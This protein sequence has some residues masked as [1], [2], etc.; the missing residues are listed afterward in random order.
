MPPMNPS[1]FVPSSLDSSLIEQPPIDLL[2]VLAI[3]VG[4]AAGV[5]PE[6]ALTCA[7]DPAIRA[8][9][10]PRLY[11]PTRILKQLAVQLSIPID[12]VE[13]VD[14]GD[15]SNQDVIAGKFS[16]ATGVASY[17]AVCR[18]VDDAML[19]KVD[20]IIT[21]PIQ[22]EAWHDAAIPFPGHTELLAQRTG[23]ERY[24][25]MLAGKELAVVLTTIHIALADVASSLTTGSILQTI[26]LAA[27]VA[28]ARGRAKGEHQTDRAVIA[29]CGLNPHAGENGL[30]SHREEEQIIQPAIITAKESGL[31]VIGPLSPDTAFTPAMRS[32]VD[33]YVCMYHDQGLIPLKALSFDDGINVTLGLPII[34]TSVD[35]GTAMD[36]A[37][38]GV[39]STTSMRAA[40]DAAIQLCR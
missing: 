6:L 39:A 12:K 22:K 3:T 8:R 2:P 35:H 40:I 5:G 30:M 21:G 19:S 4:D 27:P 29:V 18:A 38:Q 13:I 31:D 33:V 26:E 17:Q 34:R 15:L 28:V 24:A 10:R 7:A 25:M 23:T 11:G 32:R 14:V 36:L 37:W 9:C 16:A 20:A 1:P